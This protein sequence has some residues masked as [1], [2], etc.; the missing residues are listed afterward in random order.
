MV[1]EYVW[2]YR[3]GRLSRRDLIRRVLLITGSISATAAL[4][5]A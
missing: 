2:D 4:L 5:G 1:S 3:E